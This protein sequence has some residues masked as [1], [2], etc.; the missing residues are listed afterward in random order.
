MTITRALGVNVECIKYVKLV[1]YY[2]GSII[3]C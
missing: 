3:G 2:K 1:D